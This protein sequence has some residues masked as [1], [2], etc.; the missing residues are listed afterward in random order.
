[1]SVVELGLADVPPVGVLV[2]QPAAITAASDR[3]SKV[4]GRRVVLL[5]MKWFLAKQARN[6]AL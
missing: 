1:V 5:G 6:C 2:S 4:T 3:L